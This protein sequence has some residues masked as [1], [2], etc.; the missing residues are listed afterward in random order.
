MFTRH[1]IF[2]TT[3]SALSQVPLNNGTEFTNGINDLGCCGNG[4]L[5]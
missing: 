5:P 1:R 4:A 2:Y 3:S